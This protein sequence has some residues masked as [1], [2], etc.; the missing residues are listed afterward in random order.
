MHADDRH[1]VAKLAGRVICSKH[2][3]YPHHSNGNQIANDIRQA[4]EA[5]KEK[6]E[7]DNQT[8]A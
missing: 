2:S 3:Q 4:Y 8:W 1:R 5:I 6:S 7:S